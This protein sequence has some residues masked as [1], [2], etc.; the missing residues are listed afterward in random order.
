MAAS[1]CRTGGAAVTKAL[2]RTCSPAL[3]GLQRSRTAASYAQA[4]HN[5]PETQVSKLEN[6]LHIASEDSGHA[7]CTVGVWIGAGSRY[8]TEK[9]NGTAYFL[10]HLTFKG[11]KKRPQAVL[12]QEVAS[13]GAHLNAYTS[14]E[15]TAIYMK[16]QSKDLPKAVE[17]LADVVQNCSLED[18]QIEEERQV[19]LRE[20]EEID[21]C[22]E[23]VVFDYLHATAYQGTPLGRSVLGTTANIKS[24]NRAALLE[25][26]NGHY[27]APRMV[28]AAAGGVGHK[29]LH[30]LAQ[31]HFAGLSFEY[32]ADTVPVLAP[33]RFTG[34]E[35]RV[36]D[37]SLPLAHIAIAVEGP[38][39]TSP[40]KV[41]VLVANSIIGNYDRTYGGDKNLSSRVAR[42]AA[43]Y[44]MCE[45]FQTFSTCYSDTGL[46]GIHF[47]TDK[48][49]I[50]DMLHL[51]Q[52]E[53][54]RLCT[55][56]TESEVNRAK[57]ILKTALAGQLDG[58]TPVCED[59]GRHILN[60]GHRIPLEELDAQ[61][62]AVDA[63]RVKEVCTKYFYDR[64]PAVA[65]VGPIEQLPDYNRLRSA[66]YWLRF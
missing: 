23:D 38:S 57:N 49:N 31:R 54:M 61:I 18:S 43:Q 58:T 41:A 36:R 2:F 52:G 66:M 50:E 13:L 6:G 39:F 27:K 15:Q 14:R 17:I 16:A 3:L 35:I 51:S 40:D 46:L 44:K 8:E 9:N 28:L 42:S 4:L 1:V 29:E 25:Y 32:E 5:I 63:T 11:T 56:V 37:D 60:Y 20:M 30:D 21:S 65:G 12:E 55:S 26:I 10:E 7:T 47:V 48:H 24:L 53:W 59:I 22:L 19:I 62:D 34:S 45:S 33:C 64:C